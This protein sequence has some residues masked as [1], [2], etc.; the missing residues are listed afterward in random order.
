MAPTSTFPVAP[1]IYNISSA[2]NLVRF[3][4][5]ES[6]L[7]KREKSAVD[8]SGQWTV[9]S[10]TEEGLNRCTFCRLYPRELKALESRESKVVENEGRGEFDTTEAGQGP[11]DWE[12]VARFHHFEYLR[13]GLVP[14]RETSDLDPSMGAKSVG[15]PMG[16]RSTWILSV[17]SEGNGGWPPQE[18]RWA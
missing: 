3:S 17:L 11:A 9:T 12:F 16:H 5:S 13:K 8:Q 14:K 2:G 7:K 1:S 18:T 4:V 10:T 6:Q 15:P